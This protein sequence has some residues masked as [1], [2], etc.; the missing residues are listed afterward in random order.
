VTAAE[1]SC[2]VPTFERADLVSSCLAG[3]AAQRD[4]A[5]DLIVTD[6]SPGDAIRE[7]VERLTPQT[8]RPRYLEG[9]RSGNPIDNW[10]AGLDAARA[11]WR[12]VVHQDERLVDPLYL[13][14]AVDILSHTAAVACR[15][16]VTVTGV[17]RRSRFSLVSP[18]AGHMPGARRLLPLINWIGPTAAF[19]FGEGWRFDPDFVQLVDVD[20][21]AR[22]L[23]TGPLVTLPGIGVASL[24]HHDNQISARIDRTALALAELD[25]MV[26]RSPPAMS[27]L[28]HAAFA[29][30][31]K[32][33]A[34]LG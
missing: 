15:T 16:G 33:R 7:L 17:N 11:P 27:P 28:A 21:Y 19:V 9:A 5:I 4:I 2:V 3:I 8:A 26:L 18:L 30:A 23:S 22:V 20:L 10:N 25:L 31:L 6:D 29:A 34:R 1:I 14:R 13:R 32:L 24:G 12:V